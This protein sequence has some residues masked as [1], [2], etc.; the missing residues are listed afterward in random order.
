MASTP[1][2]I[3]E[4][5]LSRVQSELLNYFAAEKAESILFLI[6][7]VAVLVLC[8]FLFRMADTYRGMVYPLAIIALIQLIVGG[9]IFFRTDGQAAALTQQV[10]TQPEVFKSLEIARM[11]KV[12]TSFKWYKALEISLLVIGVAITF[13]VA[14]QATFYGVGIGLIAQSGLMLVFDLFA[15]RR[16]ESYLQAVRTFI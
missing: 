4:H 11:E 2:K 6:A 16:G 14:R 15:E 1:I 10:Q 12:M 13:F 5:K 7:G 9:S 8:V 3:M